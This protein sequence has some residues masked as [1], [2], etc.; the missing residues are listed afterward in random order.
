LKHCLTTT[1]DY[2]PDLPCISR[3][4]INLARALECVEAEKA[5]AVTA[6][7]STGSREC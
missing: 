1:G 7:A 6:T 4:R 5:A 3:R 2:R